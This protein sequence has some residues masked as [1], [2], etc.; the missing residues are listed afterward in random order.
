M[1]DSSSTQSPNAAP[2]PAAGG[3]EF[4]YKVGSGRPLGSDPE[5]S[6]HSPLAAG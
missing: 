2:A 6:K 3:R 5:P 1:A 4:Q